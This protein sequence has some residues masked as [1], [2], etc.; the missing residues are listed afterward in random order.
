[1][2]SP[3][4]PSG[5]NARVST[6]WGAAT[7]ASGQKLKTWEKS[8]ENP[9]FLM[10]NSKWWQNSTLFDGKIALFDRHIIYAC[11]IP[12]PNMSGQIQVSYGSSEDQIFL[13]ITSAVSTQPS[14]LWILYNLGSMI[15]A[16]AIPKQIKKCLQEVVADI[17]ICSNILIHFSRFPT[18]L[19]IY[20]WFWGCYT[21]KCKHNNITLT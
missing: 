4:Q 5:C 7:K 21:S 13:N 1:M 9:H 16:I 17:S 3:W 14:N 6:A 8:A 15:W 20:I 12:F 10:D 11:L 2:I 19:Y 18:F